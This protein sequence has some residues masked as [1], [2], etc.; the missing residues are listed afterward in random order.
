M[1]FIDL[2]GV[3]VDLHHGLAEHGYAMPKDRTP[4]N[5]ILADQIWD[6]IYQLDKF[7]INIRPMPMF[8][9][10]YNKILDICP[11]PM[12][13]SA[14]PECY[15]FDK[16]HYDCV[17]QKTAWVHK[18]L[19]EAQAAR[20]IITKTKLKQNVIPQI[21][22]SSHVLVD[23]HMS[24]ISRWTKAGGIGIHYNTPEQVLEKLE[25]L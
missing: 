5:K 24:N 25:R 19:G 6:K 11:E 17:F 10:V 12:I 22:A 7:W 1:I 13:L 18:H 8:R 9:E 21:S 3:M 2:D 14:T 23:D 16:R 15:G 20:S 4:E